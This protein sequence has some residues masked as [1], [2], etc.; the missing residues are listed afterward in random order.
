MKMCRLPTTILNRIAIYTGDRLVLYALRNVID[1][2][3]LM[4]GIK[5]GRTLL[6]GPVQS[7]KTDAII[8]TL[9]T[10]Y[11]RD[12][13]KVLV[14]QNSL[15]VL[16]QYQERLSAH[17]VNFHVV[18][19]KSI[20]VPAIATDTVLVLLNNSQ[21]LKHYTLMTCKPTRY[22]LLMDEA[23]TSKSGSHPLAHGATSEYYI[24][25][26][27]FHNAYREDGYFNEVQQVAVSADYTGIRD[28]QIRYKAF[29]EAMQE[30]MGVAQGMMLVNSETRVNR[31]VHLAQTVSEEY[32][33]TPVILLT[34]QKWVYLNGTRTRV[35]EMVL[36]K[37]ID[38]YVGYSHIVFVANR[39]SLRGL[40][41]VSSDY[42]RRLTHQYSNFRK[43][44]TTNCLQK[45]RLLGKG[46]T[47]VEKPVLY[48]TVE[49]E[50][51]MKRRMARLIA[52]VDRA[53]ERVL[54][55]DVSFAVTPALKAAV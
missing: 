19:A 3:F 30:F 24:T 16:K 23:D 31:M 10:P 43:T 13:H 47:G 7:G 25:A 39:M 50:A 48:L 54:N 41:Y 22:V 55:R 52:R 40:S 1:Y 45:M 29:P 5:H 44:S 34:T 8:E 11:Y 20:Q 28:I 53:T 4:G 15:V 14:I 21:R 12:L 49:G 17:Q 33:T 46:V 32:P 2:D 9:K 27:P 26:T 18:T 51:T 37:I 38:R 36:S 42:Q 35:K 6:Y